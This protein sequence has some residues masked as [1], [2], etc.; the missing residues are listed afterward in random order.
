MVA[1][2]MSSMQWPFSGRFVRKRARERERCMDRKVLG[3]DQHGMIVH[4]RFRRLYWDSN[5]LCS[6]ISVVVSVENRKEKIKKR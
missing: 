4:L 5:D 1:C 2:L 6:T 3:T